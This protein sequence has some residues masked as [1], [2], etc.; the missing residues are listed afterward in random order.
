[1]TK[2]ELIKKLKE[3]KNLGF[4][5]TQRKGDTGVGHTFEKLM[6]LRESNVAVPD[7]GGRVEV[8]AT[9][10]ESKSFIT[11]FTFNKGV[12][13]IEQ[14]KL[15]ER[16]GYIDSHGRQALKNTLFYHKPISQGLS[17]KIDEKNNVI[18]IVDDQ[19]RIIGRYD[20]Y[21]VVSKFLSKLPRVLLCIAD[22]KTI[23]GKEYFHFNEAYLLSDTNAR[24]FI[25]AFKGGLVGIDLRMHIKESG[26]VRNRGTGFRVRE[27]DMKSLYTNVEPLMLP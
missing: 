4:V 26:G 11:L 10:R 5:G 13:E 20:V 23:E 9:R 8:K 2:A 18:L 21:E 12:W 1:M 19:G 22:T 14:R 6:G 17:I 27:S 24:K 3:I 7:L 25:E 16:Y 15:V